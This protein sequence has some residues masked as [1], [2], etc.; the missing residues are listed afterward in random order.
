MKTKLKPDLQGDELPPE[1]NLYLTYSLIL[2]DSVYKTEKSH[3]P[4]EFSEECKEIVKDKKIKK[5][6]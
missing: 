1:Q 5:K 3:Y 2:A 4:Q 6:D